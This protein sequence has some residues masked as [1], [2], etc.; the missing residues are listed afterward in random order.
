MMERT[1]VML[2]P[3]ALQRGLMGE[4][5]GRIERKGYKVVAMKLMVILR[6]LAERHYAEHKGKPFFPG[7]IEYMT[8]GPVLVMVWE[9]DNIVA[10]VRAMMGKT[11]P[12]DSPLGTIRGDLAQQ[13]GRN[14]IHGSDSPES[15][16]REIGLFFNDYELVSFKRTIDPWLIE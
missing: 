14:L 13:T 4:I 2:K 5:I 1:F 7:L 9:G 6:E 3:D 8:S 15:A 12:Q 10:S 16:K 11:N